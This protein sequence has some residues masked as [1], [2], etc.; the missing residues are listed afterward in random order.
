MLL[1]RAWGSEMSTSAAQVLM[2]R[3]AIL[4]QPAHAARR[5][6]AHW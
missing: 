5:A 1:M 4:R 6:A 3:L 2:A